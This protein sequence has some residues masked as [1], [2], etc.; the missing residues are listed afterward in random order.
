MMTN[1]CSVVNFFFY[2]CFCDFFHF[3][4]S[5]LETVNSVSSLSINTSFI[6]CI[7]FNLLSKMWKN[8]PRVSS[9]FIVGVYFSQLHRLSP[10]SQR[11]NLQGCP[12]CCRHGRDWTNNTSKP[13]SSQTISVPCSR[14]HTSDNVLTTERTYPRQ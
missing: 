14:C 11:P 5:S 3:Y 9:C 8:F 12:P 6:H 13:K 7:Y 10:P 2:F 4:Y 1:S